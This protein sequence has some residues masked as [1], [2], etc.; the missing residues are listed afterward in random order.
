MA[1]FLLPWMTIDG[2]LGTAV[3]N[4]Y[5]E[6]YQKFWAIF[7]LTSMPIVMGL[8]AWLEYDPITHDVHRNS[9]GFNSAGSQLLYRE[10][11]KTIFQQG[12]LLICHVSL[13]TLPH[14]RANALASAGWPLARDHGSKA[15]HHKKPS[16]HA[17]HHPSPS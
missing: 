16:H 7:G 17:V 5:P 10:S 12:G 2:H 3:P 8:Y 4:H 6:T 11:S 9:R 14:T 1:T 13:T 15:N